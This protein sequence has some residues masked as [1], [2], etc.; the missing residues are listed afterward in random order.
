MKSFDAEKHNI[1]NAVTYARVSSIAQTKR[2]NGLSSQLTRCR[3]YASFKHYN[4]IASFE[5]D[6]SGSTTKRPG[7]DA[8]LAFLHQQKVPHVVIIDDV[9]RLSRSVK[10]H[11]ELRAAISMAG[12]VLESPTLEFGDDADSELQEYILATV[13]QHQR[14]KNA[15]QTLNRMQARVL[16][17]Y[18][19]FQCPVGYKYQKIEGHGKML[20]RNEPLASIIQEGLEGFASNRF[21]SQAE[22]MRFFQSFSEF[23]KDKRGIVRNQRVTEILT[24]PVYAGMVEAT[25]W[26][27]PLRIGKHKGLIDLKTFKKIEDKLSGKKV[28]APAR[29]DQSRD[30]PLRGGVVCS[31]GTPYTACWS[32]GQ[33]K[34][35]AY[36][37]CHNRSCKDYRKSIPRAKIEGEFEEL[38]ATVQPT[39]G[40]FDVAHAMFKDIW[41][42]R[43]TQGEKM[44]QTA[45]KEM[46]NID[47]QIEQLLDRIVDA[48]RPETI[49]AFEK[50][51]AKLE[52]EKLICQEKARNSGKPIYAFDKMF[53]HSMNFLSK[54]QK[55]WASDK[56]ELKR[57][58]LKLVFADRLIYDRIEGF[59]TPNLSLPFKAFEG[60]K[61]GKIGMAHPER[62]ER[63][64]F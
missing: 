55:L 40:L 5:D 20:V 52:K 41:N 27:I 29:K 16:N 3:E 7:M 63:P 2:G 35:Y 56:L 10:S 23:P 44:K 49:A 60:L 17:G 14:R 19:V 31:C 11:I 61:Q 42:H 9:S 54:P 26:G 45:K 15:E 32:R 18:Y 37:L 57:L 64:T 50:R 28:H 34:S 13:S 38:L 36:Y 33:L 25:S 21:A 47:K 30:F 39:K 53:E 24:R 43:L 22:L 4:V 59:R 46:A 12:G 1:K 58:V 48:T 51:I 62:F 8:M 6:L